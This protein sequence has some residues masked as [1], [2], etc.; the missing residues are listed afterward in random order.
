MIKHIRFFL[1]ILWGL[2]GC[3]SPKDGNFNK[4][5]A[6]FI[7]IDGVPADVLERVPTPAIDEISA[8]GAYTR[9]YV[10]GEINGITQTPTVS[11]DGYMSLLTSTWVNKHNIWN[12]DVSQPN[13]NYWNIFRIAKNQKRNYTT[14]IF[15]TWIEN[16]TEL[17][18][19]GKAAAGNLKMDFV[20]D[21]LELD[22]ENYP[23]EKHSLHLFK[24]DEKVSETAADC[25]REEAPDLTWVYLWYM[26]SAGHEFGDSPY[27]DQYLEL[28]DKQVARIWEAIKYREKQYGEEWMIVV[29]T[30]HGRTASNGKGHGGQ[31]ERER[32][33]WIS[34]NVMPNVYFFQGQPAITDIAVSI[35]RFMD[36]S[37]PKDVQYEQEGAPFIGEL[38]IANVK[39]TKEGGQINITW[40]NYD[41]SQVDIYLSVTNNFKNGET[42]DW[43]KVGKVEASQRKFVFDASGQPSNFYKFSLRGKHNMLPVWV[44]TNA[45]IGKDAES[46]T[47][48]P[49]PD[50]CDVLASA[51]GLWRFSDP[52]HV[53]KASLGADLT[54]VVAAGHIIP[55]EGGKVRVGANSYFSCRHGIP[56]SANGYVTEYTMLFD[57]ALPTLGQWRVFY[58]AKPGVENEGALYISTANRIGH[59]SYSSF[60][61]LSGV[62]YRLVVVYKGDGVSH[63]YIDGAFIH[64]FSNYGD[65]TKSLAQEIRFLSDGHKGYDNEIG[66]STIAI[67]DRALSDAEIAALGVTE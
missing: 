19:E 58:Q 53:D 8:R 67:W 64:R 27:F 25:I 18:G 45:S 50:L 5:K 47:V 56:P 35:S 24:I 60:S 62:W 20:L 41:N 21:G 44:K 61:V 46:D 28:A 48:A 51:K 1:L 22:K 2:S 65:H 40:D 59:G 54:S 66:I 31:S 15:S 33:T 37:I 52:K 17:I 14:A 42:D 26:D 34:T 10:G 13:Y 16:R 23:N 30:D 36:F 12:N 3:F 38:S 7:I 4:R 6:V 49:E 9:A 32:T 57:F 11:A 63:L 39:A 55:L 29:T 43:I